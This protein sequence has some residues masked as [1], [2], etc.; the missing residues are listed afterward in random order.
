[1]PKETF[2]A[3]CHS[4]GEPIIGILDYEINPKRN[5]IR[6]FSVGDEGLIERT[7]EHHGKTPV[8]SGKCNRFSIKPTDSIDRGG[9]LR[10]SRLRHPAPYLI[11]FD[12]SDG[13]IIKSDWWMESRKT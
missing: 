7:T 5:L 11:R 1:M 10:V 2:T 9:L 4:C 6:L 13:V 8:M 12:F 3:V